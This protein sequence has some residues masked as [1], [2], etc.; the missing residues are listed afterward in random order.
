[1]KPA[2]FFRR[3]ACRLRTS[4]CPS[5]SL[6][7][8]GYPIGKKPSGPSALSGPRRAS[9]LTPGGSRSKPRHP[10]LR[11]KK[12]SSSTKAPKSGGFSHHS[13]AKLLVPAGT[14][15]PD[16]PLLGCVGVLLPDKGQEWLLR[17]LAETRKDF[18]N[19]KLLL[20]GD[21]PT[22]LNLNTW[23]ANSGRAMRDL[24]RLRLMTSKMSMPPSTS[25][26][27]LLFE[28]LNNSLLAA[29]AYEIPSISFNRGALGE[30]IED[31]RSGFLVE[32][33]NIPPSEQPTPRILRD[34][35]PQKKWPKPAVTASKISPRTK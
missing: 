5:S 12:S 17:A 33:R 30:I 14:F 16:T 25:S 29:M 9:S 6:V 3:L 2:R 23:P 7:V 32:A 4:A 31:G 24:R 26:P 34:P 15:P 22:A 21:G 27:S 19:A 8:S 11:A 35:Q 20:A 10:A 18:S 13:G 28:A 1:M